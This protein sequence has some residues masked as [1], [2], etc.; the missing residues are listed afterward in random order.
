MK[1]IIDAL[2]TLAANPFVTIIC[3]IV[4]IDLVARRCF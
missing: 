2:K 3:S 1:M 4:L